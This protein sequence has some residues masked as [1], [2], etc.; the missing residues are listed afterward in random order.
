MES[1]DFAIAASVAAVMDELPVVE[2]AALERRGRLAT[3]VGVLCESHLANVSLGVVDAL[4]PAAS[5]LMLDD[6]D[7][8]A[9]R[10]VVEPHLA[11]RAR[12]AA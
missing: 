5:I 6:A 2:I 10:L 3:V 8:D 4:D 9:L 12:V 11:Y 7:V 1:S